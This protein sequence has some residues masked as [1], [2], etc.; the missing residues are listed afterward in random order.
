MDF[1]FF[2]IGITSE[3]KTLLDFLFAKS[4][5]FDVNDQVTVIIKELLRLY[6]IYT[7]SPSIF[8]STNLFDLEVIKNIHIPKDC[9][10]SFPDGESLESLSEILELLGLAEDDSN[11]LVNYAIEIFSKVRKG[12]L[13]IPNFKLNLK[14]Y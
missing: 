8:A 13:K 14:N 5:T 12:K 2:P 1:D 10:I 4:Q 7:D 3:N 9:W 6:E 11:R